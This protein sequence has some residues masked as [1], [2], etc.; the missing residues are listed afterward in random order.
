MSQLVLFHTLLEPTPA[1]TP[2]IGIIKGTKMG[3]NYVVIDVILPKRIAGTVVYRPR[4]RFL[5]LTISDL[6]GITSFDQFQQTYPEY[7]I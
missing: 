7:F 2:V 5:P 6:A 1:Y 4:L 3:P